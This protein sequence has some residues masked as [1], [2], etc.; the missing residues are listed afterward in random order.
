MKSEELIRLVL[1]SAIVA[2][3]LTARASPDGGNTFE[4]RDSDAAKGV[5]GVKASKIEPTRTEAAMKFLVVDRDKGPV[6]GVVVSLT[7]P[8][9]AEYYTDETDEAGYAEALVPVGRT[10]ELT[11]LGLGR[12]DIAATVTV[13]NEPK[14]TIKL[15][16]RYKPRPAAPP[17]VLKGVTFD[18]GKA[19]IRSESYPQLDVVADFMTHK[20]SARVEISGHTDNV[21]SSKVNKTL[22]AKRAQACRNYIMTRGV[23]GSRL[24]AVGY[25][26]ER[27]VAS[28]DTQEGRQ[29]NRRI[30]AVE[31]VE[32]KEPRP[33]PMK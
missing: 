14:Q 11:Y 27:P 30:E 24:T 15:T 29:Q 5:H 26:D 3:A 20:R 25:G 22:S 13:T 1:T 9:G 23:D 18:T 28:N 33:D 19:T 8:T 12:K 10:Y 32:G 16:L 2:S 17:F 21:G 7:S 4:L 31:L 6:K